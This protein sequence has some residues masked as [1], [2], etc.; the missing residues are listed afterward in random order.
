MKLKKE[1]NMR[2]MIL[3]LIVSTSLFAQENERI[4]TD[5]ISGGG[6]RSVDTGASTGGRFLVGNDGG[7]RALDISGGGGRLVDTNSTVR[8]MKVERR[9]EGSNIQLS[10]ANDVIKTHSRSS[11]S[12][13]RLSKMLNLRIVAPLGSISEITLKDGTVIRTEDLLEKR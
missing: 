10:D 8:L 2:Y 1:V 13:D 4:L 12:I 11:M 3:I 9:M 6:G 7:S 5:D